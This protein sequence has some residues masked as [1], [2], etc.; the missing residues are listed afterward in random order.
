MENQI[1][2]PAFAS[3]MASPAGRLTCAL[4]GLSFIAK[5]LNSKS[6]KGKFLA[7]V[8]LVPLAAGTFDLYLP[9]PVL[10]GALKGDDLRLKLHMQSGF[11]QLGSKSQYWL[12]S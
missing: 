10:G 3:F 9:S 12:K 11:P 6:R 2:F 7:L 4:I 8:G 5:G 1:K